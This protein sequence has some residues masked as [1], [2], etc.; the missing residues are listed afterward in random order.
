MKSLISNRGQL[1]LEFSILMMVILVMSV[2]SI[3]YFLEN[4]LNEEDRTLDRIEIGAKT[5]VSLVNSGYNGTN[6]DYP[7]IYVGMNYSS[8]TNIS[9]YL[10]NQ[11]PLDY[12]TLSFIRDLIYDNQNIN[13]SKYN[14]TIILI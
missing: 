5:A 12:S 13:R 11:S 4:T 7:I 10:K 3:Y 1:S 2:V 8:E 14:I 9:I 6:V